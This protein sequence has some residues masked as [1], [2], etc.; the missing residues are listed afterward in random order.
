MRPFS[1]P[2]VA[3]ADP[4]AKATKIGT[5]MF[6]CSRGAL[7]VAVAARFW[8][9]VYVAPLRRMQGPASIHVRR[10]NAITWKLLQ[11]P[12]K[13]MSQAIKPEGRVGL[14]SGSGHRKLAGKE[15][16]ET[17]RAWSTRLRRTSPWTHDQ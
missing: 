1:D 17:K 8:I 15:G 9:M 5:N 11:C 7:A 4:G 3:G 2:D 14:R 6:V 12:G 10:L 13:N 16:D